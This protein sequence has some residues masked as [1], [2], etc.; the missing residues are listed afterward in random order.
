MSTSTGQEIV[1]KV[2]ND[3]GE[4]VT[5]PHCYDNVMSCRTD[6]YLKAIGKNCAAADPR[7]VPT[8]PPYLDKNGHG[9]LGP[10]SQVGIAAHVPV[11]A[12]PSLSFSRN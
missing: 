4:V 9:K 11:S 10:M 2:Y 1:C 6:P 3:A 12:Q 8:M 5:L 7:F